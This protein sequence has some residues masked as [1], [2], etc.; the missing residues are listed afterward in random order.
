MFNQRIRIVSAAI[1][2]SFLVLIGALFYFQVIRSAYYRSLSLRNSLRVIPV[3]ASRGGIYDRTGKV[4]AKDEISFD[5]VIIPQEVSDID[6]T[7]KR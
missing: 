5:L 1:L 2:A 6:I 7:L 3:Q 4:F